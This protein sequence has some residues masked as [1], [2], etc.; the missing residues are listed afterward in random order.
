MKF[1]ITEERSRRIVQSK[2][3]E[4]PFSNSIIR[5]IDLFDLPMVDKYIVAYMEESNEYLIILW[6]KSGYY[7]NSEF[8]W[9]LNKRIQLFIPANMTI[10]SGPES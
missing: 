4:G 8:C 5:L 9:K 1:I 2:V 6:P 7:I 3:D 10:V